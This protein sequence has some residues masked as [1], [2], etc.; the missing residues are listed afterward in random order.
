MIT[1]RSEGSEREK[2]RV[3]MTTNINGQAVK[4]TL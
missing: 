1:E 2:A 4:K 3:V